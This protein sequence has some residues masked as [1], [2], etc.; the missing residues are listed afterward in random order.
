MN[1]SNEYFK[2]IK[3]LFAKS[4]TLKNIWDRLD[5]KNPI[6]PFTDYFNNVNERLN[7]IW[8]RFEINENKDRSQF[9]N[10]DRIK[11]VQ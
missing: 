4:K 11:M 1:D 7:A 2:D 10:M 6:S 9:N 8:R 3:G 5:L